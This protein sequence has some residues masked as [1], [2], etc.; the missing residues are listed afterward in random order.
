MEQLV[1]K[2][3][4]LLEEMKRFDQENVTLNE[5]FEEMH[6]ECQRL[7]DKLMVLQIE[8]ERQ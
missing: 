2:K 6:E 4:N 1:E 8:E 7:G 5:R 3:T